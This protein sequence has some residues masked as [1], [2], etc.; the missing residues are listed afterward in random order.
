MSCPGCPVLTH[1]SCP[2]CIVPAA[3]PGYLVHCS[4]DATVMSWQSCHLFPSQA[5]LSRLTC[6]ADLLK[7]SCPGFPVPVVLSK[8]S[9]P[10]CP[11]S[12]SIVVSSTFPI[13]AL[14]SMLSCFGHSASVAYPGC[15]IPTVSSDFSVPLLLSDIP[16]LAVLSWLSFPWCPAPAVLLP[17]VLSQLSCSSCPVPT[18]LSQLSSSSSTAQIPLST[19]LLTLLSCL[20]NVLSSPLCPV[21]VHP[22]LDNLSG[23]PVMLTCH[24]DL[25]CWPVQTDLSW[26]YCPSGPVP[27][28]LCQLTC[29]G[30]PIPLSCPSCNVRAVLFW[31]SC[32]L[33]PVWMYYPDCLLWL[34]SSCYRIPYILPQQSF[35][36]ALLMLLSW[37]CSYVPA[38][39]LYSA[40]AHL[41][42]L[43]CQLTCLN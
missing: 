20:D 15:T 10:R 27:D 6:W 19:V 8:W 1:L 25:S 16:A 12:T 40:Q 43:S 24:A 36:M 35:S 9:C 41:S 5:D 31:Q 23:W 17:A 33:F 32:P 28:V 7:L 4:P 26:L 42:R 22:I 11:R 13:L 3:W 39:P 30:C 2:G 38:C 18:V 37:R 34:S 21:Q 14:L 29:H